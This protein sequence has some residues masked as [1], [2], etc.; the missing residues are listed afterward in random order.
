M[1]I[2][3]ASPSSQRRLPPDVLY[4]IFSE[5]RISLNPDPRPGLFG[6]SKWTLGSYRTLSNICKASKQFKV[7]AQPLLYRFI[8]TF[9]RDKREPDK[10]LGTMSANPHLGEWVHSFD[11]RYAPHWQ[12]MSVK[13]GEWFRQARPHL[14]L[15]PELAQEVD[16]ALTRLNRHILRAVDATATFWLCMMPNLRTLSLTMMQ[17]AKCTYALLKHAVES[18]DQTSPNSPFSSLQEISLSQPRAISGHYTYIRAAEALFK[19]PSLKTLRARR[20]NWIDPKTNEAFMFPDVE[21]PLQHLYSS[22]SNMPPETVRSVLAGCKQLQTLD[23]DLGMNPLRFFPS[24]YDMGAILR[25]HGQHL[26][27]IGISFHCHDTS[28]PDRQGESLTGEEYLAQ[29]I[30][31]LGCLPLLKHFRLQLP[32]ML[33]GSAMKANGTGLPDLQLA[34]ML[35]PSI[36]TVVLF[37]EFKDKEAMAENLYSMAAASE[38]LPHLRWVM[39]P[40]AVKLERDLTDLGWACKTAGGSGPLEVSVME[41]AGAKNGFDV[42]DFD[43]S[44]MTWGHDLE[45]WQL[46]TSSA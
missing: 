36:E 15:P 34:E 22:E 38:M 31:D 5:C 25:D 4:L 14:K 33:S 35:P 30:G 17:D 1:D 43:F 44:K 11:L 20:I 46:F 9:P 32:A 16:T 10:L 40:S 29:N 21:C 3:H 45:T 28:D 13:H 27:R 2:Q 23:L 6:I 42:K 26:E 7:I 8:L 18:M 37:C 39:V 19:L 24:R 41:R 12:T